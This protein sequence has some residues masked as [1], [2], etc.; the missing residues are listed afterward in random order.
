MLPLHKFASVT[1]NI[2]MSNALVILSAAG[3]FIALFPVHIYNYVYV[4]TGE[5]YASLNVSAFRL[6]RIFNANTIKNSP[7]KM[8]ING[9]DRKVNLNF[10]K[11]KPLKIFNSL[12]LLKVVQLGDFG[13]LSDSSIYFALGQNVLSNAVYSFIEANGGRTKLK[14]YTVLNR[15]HG[16]VVYYAKIVG[17][18]NLI[19]VTKIIFMLLTEKINEQ[20]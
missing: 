3:F 4:N 20:T 16:K 12:C 9:R 7:N 17:V 5:K 19:T 18:I 11:S 15:E 1:D 2:N 6:I 14:N 8:Q 13:L 10:V